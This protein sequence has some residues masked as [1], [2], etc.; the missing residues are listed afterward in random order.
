MGAAAETLP[1]FYAPPSSRDR[2]AVDDDGTPFGRTGADVVAAELTG[3]PW[4][5]MRIHDDPNSTDCSR[6]R[7]AVY[8]R[9]G[10]STFALA[11]G[12]DLDIGLR[13]E[14]CGGWI[15]DEWHDHAVI[16]P[17]ADASAARALANQGAARLRAWALSDPVR[18][19]NLFALGAAV[20]PGDRP[21]YF[22]S[23]FRTI[24]GNMRVYV[25]AG[26]PAYA[27]GLRSGEVIESIDGKA[28][29]LYGTYPAQELAYDGKPHTFEVLQGGR[30]VD[31]ALRAP[32]TATASDGE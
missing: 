24:D 17:H 32:F 21:A 3:G 4:T 8:L 25:R 2:I 12:D 31:I 19:G 23:L 26:G 10:S 7:Y 27:A 22:Y 16:A 20:R 28:W 5:A 6:K 13:L 29:W 15:V 14:D 9:V 11:S 1:G 30:A 18:S